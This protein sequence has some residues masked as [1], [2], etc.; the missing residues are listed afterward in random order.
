MI[1]IKSGNTLTI[2]GPGRVSVYGKPALSGTQPV[3]GEVEVE[4]HTT[5]AK[6]ASHNHN[7][8]KK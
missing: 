6:A 2:T 7:K 3:P 5:S 8:A 4:E 1:E